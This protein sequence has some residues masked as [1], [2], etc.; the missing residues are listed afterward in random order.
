MIVDRC[1][2]LLK[3]TPLNF[4]PAAE[5]ARGVVNSWVY[6]YDLPKDLITDNE[7]C[8]TSKFFQSVS[9]MIGPHNSFTTTYHL[10]SNRQAER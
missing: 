8:F 3:T 1:T 9:Q 7:K 10:Q 2:K 4:Q 5:F 6:S